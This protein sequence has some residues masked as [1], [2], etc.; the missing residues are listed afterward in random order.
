MTGK[1]RDRRV[2]GNLF[3]Y[4]KHRRD[5]DD[6][7]AVAM[8]QNGKRW[9]GFGAHGSFKSDPA[10][11]GGVLLADPPPRVRASLLWCEAIEDAWAE[12]RMLDDG[13]ERGLA[14]LMEQNFCLDGVE[15]SKDKNRECR[16]AICAA[17][18]ISESTFYQWLSR[19][20]E[21]T[22]YHAARRGLV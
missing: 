18:G 12:C 4:A 7:V 9:D 22:G 2:Q 20:T 11:R 10:A 3:A 19:V 16:A 6:F 5:V 17:C 13:N 15:R 1:D 14:Y 8:R 21:I